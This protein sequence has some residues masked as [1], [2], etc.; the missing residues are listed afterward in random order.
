L[1][2]LKLNVFD[3]LT[4][5]LMNSNCSA[6]YIV[7]DIEWNRSGEELAGTVDITVSRDVSVKEITMKFIG[8]EK[9]E[10][11]GQDK[12]DIRSLFNL[13]VI[14]A[15]QGDFYEG[16]YSYPFQC[17][18]PND[19]PPTT[20]SQ[21][22]YLNKKYTMIIYYEGIVTITYSNGT[23]S[24]AKK[25]FI[26]HE[27]GRRSKPVLSA[28]NKILTD[29]TIAIKLEFDRDVF[30]QNDKFTIESLIQNDTNTEILSVNVKLIEQIT[31]GGLRP[32]EYSLELY[33]DVLVGVQPKTKDK[34][35]IPIQL[36]PFMEPNVT[37]TLIQTK[38]TLQV[39]LDCPMMSDLQCN[40]PIIIKKVRPRRNKPLHV[41]RSE[42]SR[43][44]SPSPIKERT[45]LLKRHETSPLVKE[46]TPCCSTCNLQ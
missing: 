9:M 16:D 23:T 12:P 20:V 30:V 43:S 35:P 11:E 27:D 33:S 39:T 26:I 3:W 44:P 32:A 14:V 29:G 25:E 8:Y 42:L 1:I 5:W 37:G 46:R 10:C 22:L 36:P 18:L 21:F 34:R 19:I 28:K 31:V 4:H 45:R 6:L 13:Q 38:Y 41:R 24:I 40:I 7:Y 17:E 2:G 15:E